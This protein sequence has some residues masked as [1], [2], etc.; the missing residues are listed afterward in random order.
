MSTHHWVFFK[1]VRKKWFFSQLL[2]DWN[3]IW[4]GNFH[5][6]KC[7][8]KDNRQIGGEQNGFRLKYMYKWRSKITS[9]DNVIEMRHFDRSSDGFRKKMKWKFLESISY[10]VFIIFSL[11]IHS[12][13]T[14]NNLT[15][16]MDEFK[17]MT[18]SSASHK[19]SL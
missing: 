8:L 3:S 15:H 14:Q 2:R 1:S 18:L 12:T 11:F 9:F 4:P 7:V 19:C 10:S 13:T 5:V 17:Q 16:V 6:Y